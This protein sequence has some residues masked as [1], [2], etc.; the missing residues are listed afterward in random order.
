MQAVPLETKYFSWDGR[1]PILERW[2]TRSDSDPIG[3]HYT[4]DANYTEIT[5]NEQE[6][7]VIFEEL[8]VIQIVP[9]EVHAN[10][11]WE[12]QD[13]SSKIRFNGIWIIEDS[14]W[15][16]S[17]N[18]QHLKNHNHYILE[19]YDDIVEVICKGLKFGLGEYTEENL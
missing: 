15:L 16:K 5:S 7:W 19:F 3:C 14:H 18:P 6:A 10:W 12:Y 9:E 13:N 2:L 11:Q 8:Q 1:G 4:F 17:F